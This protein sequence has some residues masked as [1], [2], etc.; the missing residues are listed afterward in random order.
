M[1][2][3][4]IAIF[5]PDIVVLDDKVCIF[6]SDQKLYEYNEKQQTEYCRLIKKLYGGDQCVVKE[7][8]GMGITIP[9]NNKLFWETLKY[10]YGK[11]A[12]DSMSIGK[13]RNLMGTVVEA[14]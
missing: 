13:Y 1:S 8:K 9:K 7:V 11:G 4:Y 10:L 3:S 5:A 14:T 6:W 12:L 2:A